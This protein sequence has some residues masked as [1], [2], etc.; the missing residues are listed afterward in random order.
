MLA[1]RQLNDWDLLSDDSQLRIAHG[2]M[3]RAAE[4]MA[5]HAELLASEM[6]D[7]AVC[8]R[9]GPEALRLLANMV[10]LTGRDIMVTVGNA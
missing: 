2:A 1:T 4:A 9:G 5:G 7:G 3:R 8:D 10:R 6:E